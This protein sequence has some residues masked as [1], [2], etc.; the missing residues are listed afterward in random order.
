M[1]YDKQKLIEQSLAAIKEHKLI[2]IEEVV[3]FLPCVKSTFY[4]HKLDESNDIQEALQRSKIDTKVHL[5]KRWRDSD[6]AALQIMLYRLCSTDSE[7]EKMTM[8]KIKAEVKA[9][10]NQKLDLS[11]LSNDE[12]NTLEGIINNASNDTGGTG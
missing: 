4:D 5:R 3:S 7:L 2:F 12:L 9:D 8:Q 11:K 10:I 6:V 1:A